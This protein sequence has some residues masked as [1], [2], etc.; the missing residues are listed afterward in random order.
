M[1]ATFETGHVKN[2]ANFQQLITYCIS[3]GAEYNPSNQALTVAS[4]QN[5]LQAAEN[6]MSNCSMLEAAY[7][8]AAS[9]KKEAFADLKKLST[10]VINAF[11][12]SGVSKT[13][14][15]AARHIQ[16]K[17]QGRRAGNHQ[18]SIHNTTAPDAPPPHKT[19]SVS[20]QG[21]DNLVDHF[22]S[23]IELVS[24][25]P[26]YKPNEARLKIAALQAHLE[27]L[28][29]AN[30]NTTDAYVAYSNGRIHRNE[31]LYKTTSG[32]VDTALSVKTYIKSIFGI[33]S[34][35]YGQIKGIQFRKKLSL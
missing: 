29:T 4:L 5:Q 11:A 27:T 26:E 32:L 3:Y 20:H 23:L 22:S 8:N 18:T 2:V 16:R 17:I 9:I 19:I 14:I 21:Y 28:K 1:P 10:K 34:P 12:V 15:E 30:N 6:A 7:T 25:H 33:A 31:V 13:T 35:H 24:S